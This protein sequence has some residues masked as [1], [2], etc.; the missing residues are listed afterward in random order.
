MITPRG[1]IN[2]VVGRGD[3]PELL[4]QSQQ[5]QL[6]LGRS[7]RALRGQELRDGALDQ[8]RPHALVLGVEVAPRLKA[9]ARPP[10][11]LERAATP[12]APASTMPVALSALTPP[13]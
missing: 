6:E 12:A 9:P 4:L 5:G 11:A 10:N 13:R 7:R 3:I 2:R 8:L 1:V